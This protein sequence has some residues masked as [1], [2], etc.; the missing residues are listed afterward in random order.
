LSVFP[1]Q[2]ATFASDG[3]GDGDG[4]GF[5]DP[6]AFVVRRAST[7]PSLA[8][9][10]AG[11]TFACGRGG[12]PLFASVATATRATPSASARDGGAGGAGGAVAFAPGVSFDGCF[13]DG[14]VAETGTRCGVGRSHGR[15][16]CRGDDSYGYPVRRGSEALGGVARDPKDWGEFDYDD[17]DE[18]SR[19]EEFYSFV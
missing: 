19:R 4:D 9:K 3:D 17:G 5:F 6:D 12:V 2:I 16:G 11:V 15:S 13:L 18:H 10:D 8:A 7:V 1:D 14:R